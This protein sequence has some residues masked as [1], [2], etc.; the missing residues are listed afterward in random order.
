M[1]TKFKMYLKH[2]ACISSYLF[3]IWLVT[4]ISRYGAKASRVWNGGVG[5]VLFAE[6]LVAVQVTNNTEFRRTSYLL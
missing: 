1:S 2:F 3:A 6:R 5:I 4:D